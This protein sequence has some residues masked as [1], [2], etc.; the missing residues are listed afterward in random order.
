MTAKD[1]AQKVRSAQY[2]LR[3][4]GPKSMKEQMAVFETLDN[5][6]M[7]DVYG[8]GEVIENFEKLLSVEFGKP[9]AVFFPSGTM[10]Q[11]IALRI[12][13]DCKALKR[14]AYHPLC[15]LEIHEQDGIKELH[16]IETILLGDP[17]RVFTLEDLK[18]MG[19][20]AVV[21]FE[22]PQREIGG[23]LPS[24]DTLVSMVNYC[25][26]RGIYTH[27]DGARIYECLPYYQ[28]TAAEV[29][30]LFDSVYVSFYKTFGA[31]T[32]AM[33][34][35]DDAMMAEAKI[36]K[37]R[38]GGD[39]YQLFPYIVTASDAFLNKKDKM[40][41][42]YEGAKAYAAKLSAVP[43]LRIIPEVPVTNMFHVY[44]DETPEVVMDQLGQVIDATGVSLF[45]GIGP[46]SDGLAKSEINI[47]EAYGKVAEHFI[48]QAISHFTN[49]RI[50]K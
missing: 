36:W 16:Q 33:L 42:Y 3:G 45:G 48:D 17:E 29:G 40:T 46:K 43:G 44:F 14:V 19:E 28:K 20:V 13:C 21:L 10:A 9:A 15:H 24:W 7:S 26:E 34:I 47:A 41:V 49:I 11:Q 23:Q 18:E 30:Q 32:G 8:T 50:A 6:L 37:R 38:H 2:Q 35:G 1:Y 25:K 5:A 31:V 27:L 4:N 39:L 22:L 12:H